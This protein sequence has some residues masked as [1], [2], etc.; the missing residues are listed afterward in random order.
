M[1]LQ[2]INSEVIGLKSG[3]ITAQI[4]GTGIIKLGERETEGPGEYDIAGIGIHSYTGH[5]VL[6]AEG[7]RLAVIWDPNAKFDPE[8]ELNIDVFVFLISDAKQITSFIKEQD[9]RIVVFHNPEVAEEVARLD[10]VSIT[11]ESSYKLSPQTLPMDERIFV[12]LV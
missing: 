4:K 3:Q 11:Q 2:H 10:G 9:P 1:V 5:A 12:L 7:I 6:F 8:E